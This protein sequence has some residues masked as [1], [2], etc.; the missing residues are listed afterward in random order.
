MTEK[1]TEESLPLRLVVARDAT[2]P[3]SHDESPTAHP[4]A[5]AH[6]HG[7]ASAAFRH[8][9]L[10]AYQVALRM[11]ALGKKLSEQV[12]RGDRNVADH[13]LR[14]ASNSV[15]LLAEGAN[16]RGAGEKRQRFVESRGECGEVGA[17]ADLLLAY[18]IGSREE[19][20]ELKH[21]AARVSALLTRLIA[22]LEDQR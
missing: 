16:R 11:A 22:R 20:E 6:V 5:H 4:H 14:A 12:S 21:L 15:L 7:P 10:D 18:D 3:T 2:R 9:R 8:E 17:A 1:P 19:V 13:M